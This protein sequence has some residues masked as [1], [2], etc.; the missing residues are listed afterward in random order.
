MPTMSASAENPVCI[1]ELLSLSNRVTETRLKVNVVLVMG[2]RH[3]Y[4]L[5]TVSNDN[6]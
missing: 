1:G 3:P 4:R 2:S 6:G 5:E